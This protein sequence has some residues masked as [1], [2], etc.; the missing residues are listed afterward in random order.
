MNFQEEVKG[1]LL[2]ESITE[3]GTGAAICEMA[4]DKRSECWQPELP[5]F[6]RIDYVGTQTTTL[7]VSVKNQIQ[8]F[9]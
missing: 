6:A 3:Q 7:N 5:A 2:F 9:A 4:T 8:T 1:N